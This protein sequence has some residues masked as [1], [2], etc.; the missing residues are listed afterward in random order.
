MVRRPIRGGSVGGLP[1]FRRR[2]FTGADVS[3]DRN[4]PDRGVLVPRP[5]DYIGNLFE[6]RRRGTPVVR[7][8]DLL[9]LRIEL[10]NLRIKAGAPPV[11]RKSGTGAAYLILH[12]PP[13]AITEETFFEESPEGMEETVEDPTLAQK[14]EIDP[15]GSESAAVPPP[16]GRTINARIADESRLVFRV[17]DDA[18]IPYTLEGILNAV[19]SLELRVAANARARQIRRRFAWTDTL[20]QTSAL[21]SLGPA[22]RGALTSFAAASL[23]IAATDPG[24]ATLLRRQIGG[25]A[26]ITDVSRLPSEFRIPGILQRPPKPSKPN[27]T[28]T[29]IEIPWRLILSP[30]K[31]TRWR[32]AAVPV[33]SKATNHTELWHSRL[34]APDEGGNV[35]EPPHRDRART[36]RAIWAKTGEGSTVEM[37]PNATEIP[38]LQ[39]SLAPFRM[40]MD[41]FD[42]IQIAHESSNFSLGT[43][44][45]IDTN[46]MMMTALGGW[47]DSRGAWDPPGGFSVQEWVHRASMARDHYVKVVYN[48][49]L[50]PLNFFATLVKIS[51]RKFHNGSRN[52]DEE[53]QIEQVEGNTAYLRQRMFIVPREKVREYGGANL[54]SNDGK[55]NLPLQFPFSKI[56][57]LTERT[58][59]LDDPQKSDID[60]RLQ[61]FF[62][63]SV[64][65]E[66]FKFQCVGTDL[67]GRRVAFE[68]PMIF[69]DNTFATPFKLMPNGARGPDYDLAEVHAMR[70]VE[71]F[72]TRD[73]RKT[74]PI[75][76][77]R[78]ALASSLKSGDTSVEV[79]EMDFEG[80]AE[81]GNADL[82]NASGGLER[83]PFVPVVSGM[84]VRI[85]ALSHLTGATAANRLLYHPHYLEHGFEQKGEVFARIEKTSGMAK[86]DF[87]AQGDR[88]GGFVQPNLEPQALSRLAG[89]VMGDIQKFARDGLVPPGGGF[90]DTLTD[91]PLPLI[92]GCIPLA[93]II[94]QVADLTDTPEQIPKFGTE[95]STQVESFINGLVRLISFAAEIVSQ[96]ANIATA[97]LTG[98]LSTLTDHIQ[99]TIG[100]SA[101]QAAQV[102]AALSELETRLQ[103]VAAQ[104]AGL[105]DQTLQAGQ[106]LPDFGA[107]PGTIT[108]ARAAIVA[109][110][111]AAQ[112]Q[113]GGASLPAGFRQ[114]LLSTA[115]TADNFL[116]DL[117]KLP[118]LAAAG[119]GLFDALDTIVGQ[120]E[121]LGALF[122]D[123]GEL[124]ARVGAVETAIG[125]FRPALSDI[126]LLNGAP[127]TAILD[128]LQL[129]E[130]SFGVASDLLELIDM[131]TG[132]E[133]TIRFDWNPKIGSFPSGDPIF[134][135][136]DP[137]GF[138]VAVEAKVKK[139]GSAS[140]KISVVCGL[141]HFD[142]VLIAPA[143]F[144]ELIFEKIE[145]RIDSAAKMDV[146]VQFTDIKFVGVLSFVETLRDLI[147]L[148]G[149][150]DPPFLDITPQGI[151]AGFSIALPGITCGILN[152][153]NLSL[154]AGFTVPFIGQPLSVRFNF[155]TREQ[156]FLLTV[157]MFGGGGFFGITIDPN[158]VQILEASFEFGASISIDLGVASGGV[159]VMAGIYF[160]MEQDEASLTGYFRL[161]GHVDVLGLITASLELYLELRYEF[162]TGKCVGKASL[163]IEISVFIFSGSVTVSCE[164]KFAG[165]NG[166]PNLRQML[167]FRPELSLAEELAAITG[168]DVEYAWRDHVEAFA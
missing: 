16:F 40:P 91:L 143:S 127:K 98:Y 140:P 54:R 165:S 18:V 135:A 167:G 13:Q 56:E 22:R 10:R 145:F 17:P 45:P 69:M 5:I 81:N 19:Q 72:G 129:V 28:T 67:D 71:E 88:S 147:P 111:T 59:N 7:P 57:L 133:L 23:R 73:T 51:E 26:G 14:P 78:V 138:S 110:Q 21:A 49:C 155:C 104:I 39:P 101:A 15:P 82:R 92:F 79:E 1:R 44:N 20:I 164:R 64:L 102:A 141:K 116:A 48:G 35:I 84:D 166:D 95:A 142:L 9:A 42:R 106:P 130:E 68:I 125:A 90:P 33:T 148:D 8:T 50:F 29:A 4:F 152:I 11:L 114:Q 100:L 76:R 153:N 137:K 93:E 123:P 156:P 25:G 144:I 97:A 120:P 162:Q 159:S 86:L 99:Q 75:K 121:A 66:P 74:V 70:A 37:T 31:D 30:H 83:A 36:L 154:G 61:Q 34:V 161:A 58:P 113:V 146:D 139:N 160:R 77:Q 103:A 41:D 150:S 85:G 128:A 32:H 131:L 107:L 158:G 119:K 94:E 27:A 6:T 55:T 105:V 60:G 118:A 112:A 65:D 149:F 168:D 134:R 157:Y 122:E 89:P 151:D 24:N 63:P 2:V 62:W 46:L 43:P 87:S 108:Q 12:F 117:E 109:L 115:Q 38:S 47:L 3:I 80:F 53:P 52:D 96:P 124:A 163:T 126:D 132:D 136:N